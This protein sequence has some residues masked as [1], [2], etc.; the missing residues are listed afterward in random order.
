MHTWESCLLA[1]GLEPPSAPTRPGL[2]P[3]A[4]SAQV[5]RGLSSSR[6]APPLGHG[7]GF[8]VQT[9]LHSTEEAR[10]AHQ[11][12]RQSHITNPRCQPA[13]PTISTRGASRTGHA[14]CYPIQGASRNLL[15]P[16][17]LCCHHQGSFAFTQSSC[18]VLSAV[19][20][21]SKIFL[22]T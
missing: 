1:P 2:I 11:S 10:L 18:A 4:A 15:E 7:F 9:G 17:G 13:V 21:I 3:E 5:R 8:R 6:S 19:A 22:S 14:G 20:W 12:R 16:W